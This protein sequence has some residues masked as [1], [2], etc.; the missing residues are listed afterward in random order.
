[1]MSGMPPAATATTGTPDAIAS[2]TT[3]PSVSVSE[4]MRKT[5]AEAY[6]DERAAPVSMPVNTVGVPCFA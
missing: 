2:S 3:K 1:M 4:G 6:A 5:S